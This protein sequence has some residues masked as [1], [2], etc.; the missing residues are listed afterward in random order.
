MSARPQAASEHA[1]R[2]FGSHRCRTADSSLGGRRLPG[3]RKPFVAADGRPII[4]GDNENHYH[5][6]RIDWSGCRVASGLDF[7]PAVGNGIVLRTAG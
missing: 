4:D 3:R 1:E 5:S 2:P 7:A 6:R